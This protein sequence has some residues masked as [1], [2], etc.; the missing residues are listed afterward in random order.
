[1]TR[2]LFFFPFLDSIR[3]FRNEGILWKEEK[4]GNTAVKKKVSPCL[5][6]KKQLMQNQDESVLGISSTVALQLLEE[7]TMEAVHVDPTQIHSARFAV[8]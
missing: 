8:E 1:M 2:H 4:K 5:L 7:T 6:E 3:K